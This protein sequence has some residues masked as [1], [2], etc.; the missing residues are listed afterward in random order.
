[1]FRTAKLNILQDYLSHLLSAKIMA[2]LT[3]NPKSIR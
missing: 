1:M 3:L 2:Y